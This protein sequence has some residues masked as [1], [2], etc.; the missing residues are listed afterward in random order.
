MFMIALKKS[1]SFKNSQSSRL[2]ETLVYKVTWIKYPRF[3]PED[4]KSKLYHSIEGSNNTIRPRYVLWPSRRRRRNKKKE[5]EEEG[6]KDEIAAETKVPGA[7]FC[8]FKLSFKTHCEKIEV[9]SL[10]L[11]VSFGLAAARRLFSDRPSFL[12]LL[13]QLIFYGIPGRISPSHWL[14]PR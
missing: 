6:G 14:I 1:K 3:F 12:T 8:G 4:E 11:H 5:R 9:A 7:L 2:L 10:A 13:H